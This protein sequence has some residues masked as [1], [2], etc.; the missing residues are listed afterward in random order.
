MSTTEFNPQSLP[1]DLEMLIGR[2]FEDEGKKKQ[3]VELDHLFDQLKNQ[4]YSFNIIRELKQVK[5]IPFKKFTCRKHKPQAEGQTPSDK[6]LELLKEQKLQAVED[7]NF[8]LAASYRDKEA[9]MAQ[10]LDSN[11]PA[12]PSVPS[13]PLAIFNQKILK[14]HV[15]V[16]QR[17]VHIYL[18]T[19]QE[20]FADK[21]HSLTSRPPSNDMGWLKK[22]VWCRS[23]T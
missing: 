14:T 22:L 18:I 4:G 21:I 10:A 15:V 16:E 19:R 5:V 20:K 23:I 7:G 12:A 17:M 1:S 3:F 9:V 11:G 13:D 6:E 8:E 2:A